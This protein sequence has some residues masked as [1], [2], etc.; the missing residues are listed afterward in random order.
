[1]SPSYHKVE[2]LECLSSSLSILGSMN[3]GNISSAGNSDILHGIL[4]LSSRDSSNWLSDDVAFH[5][6]YYAKLD[7]GLKHLSKLT[8]EH[9]SWED[10]VVGSTG[11][12]ICSGEYENNQFLG[13]VD[14]FRHKFYTELGHYEQKFSLLPLS[15]IRKVHTISYTC[16]FLPCVTS[17]FLSLSAKEEFKFALSPFQI[18]ASLYN[19]GLF[20]VGYD[21]FHGFVNQELSQDKMQTVDRICLYS[22]MSKPFFKATEETALLFSRFVAAC[23]I[24]FSQLKSHYMEIDVSCESRCSWS[25]AWVYYI[26]CLM[27]SSRILRASLRI[28]C[29]SLNEDLTM[30]FLTVLD[31]I[32]YL[33]HFAFAWLQ[34]NSKGLFLMLEPL[35]IKHT[36]G[37]TLYEVDIAKL[38][39]LLPQISDIASQSSLHDDVGKGPQISKHLL[40]D[41]G[42][43]IKHSIPEDERWKI[44]GA[45][46]WQHVSRF[47]KHKLK[48]MSYKLE[49]SYFS[50][51]SHGLSSESCSAKNLGS[52]DKCLEEQIGLVSLT[53]VKLLKTTVED[54]SSY[55]VKQLASFL[56]KKIEYGWHVK[57]LVWLEESSQTRARV[58]H[59]NL[60][61]HIAGLD[62][63]NEKE[64]FDILWDTCADPKMISESFV[65]EKISTL[66]WFDHKP[67]K[68][69]SDIYE[70]VRGVDEAEE[71]HNQEATPGSSSTS[72]ETG[73][74]ARQP[75]RHGLSF[76]SLWQ[77]DTTVTHRIASFLSPREV[78][79]RNGELLEV[80]LLICF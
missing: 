79:K 9:P 51:L 78:L 31:L 36:D 13:L 14:S 34:R 44:V 73:S 37:H 5:L 35:L 8:R 6:E 38:K 45:C 61:Q 10:I 74:P 41:Q 52:D 72:T 30:K 17:S 24:T 76:F 29:G 32:E 22:L 12:H 67:S 69:W 33:V 7:L 40:D 54:V 77:K 60:G 15:L 50:G 21:L 16:A 57:T 49:D 25:N 18:L 59:Q 43:D 20:V 1:M 71:I 56:R 23:N 65:E 4:K 28:K 47:M 66:D 39:K 63:M 58:P 2:A 26:Q 75:P 46:L 55:H 27:L 3:K 42:L 64:G 53:L 48:T 68:G 11:A 62:M 19:Q 80:A 70:G